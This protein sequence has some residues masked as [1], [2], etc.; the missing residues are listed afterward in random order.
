MT[1]SVSRAQRYARCAVC[2]QTIVRVTGERWRHEVGQRRVQEWHL[3]T[4]RGGMMTARGRRRAEGAGCEPGPGGPPPPH[5][6]WAS[7]WR[8]NNT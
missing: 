5:F 6:L 4:P 1:E 8:D 7:T 2:G 3:A